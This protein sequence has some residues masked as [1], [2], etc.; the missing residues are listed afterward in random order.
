[1]NH[2]A[3]STLQAL[4]SRLALGDRAACDPAFELLWPIVRRFA[5]RALG[6]APEAEDAA[7]DILVKVFARVAQYDASQNALPW[8]LSIAA[9]ECKTYRQ[10]RRRNKVVT[11]VDSD[12]IEPSSDPEQTVIARDLDAALREAV[13]ALSPNDQLALKAVLDEQREDAMSATLRKQLSRALARLRVIWR[14]RHGVD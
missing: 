12:A 2:T 13:Q 3:A 9:Y 1:M 7:Q 10:K 14:S 6:G 4:L 5:E 8:V 11:G